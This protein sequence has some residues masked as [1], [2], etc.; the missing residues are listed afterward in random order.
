MDDHLQGKGC[1]KC[2]H[3]ESNL[4]YVVKL[5]NN[6]DSFI[7][8]GITSK[9]KSDHMRRYYEYRKLGYNVE[10][11]YEFKFISET[12]ARNVELSL[13][14]KLSTFRFIPKV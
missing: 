5:N 8:L 1:S 6:L 2:R 10:T 13:I 3:K 14:K 4:L 12:C 9:K 11:L 7:K